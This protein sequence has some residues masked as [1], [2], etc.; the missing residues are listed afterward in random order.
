MHERNIETQNIMIQSIKTKVLYKL[1]DR[2]T[3]KEFL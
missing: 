2:S 3:I 1:K